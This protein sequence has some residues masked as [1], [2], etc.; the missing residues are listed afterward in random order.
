MIGAQASVLLNL[1]SGEEHLAE[2]MADFLEMLVR[3]YES[4]RLAEEVL[5]CVQLL[6]PL[7]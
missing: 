2:S 4:S 1:K 6:T 3:K 5:R 7:H